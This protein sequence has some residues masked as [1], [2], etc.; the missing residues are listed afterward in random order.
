MINCN[1][2]CTMVSDLLGISGQ[3]ISKPDG[4]SAKLDGDSVTIFD[5]AVGSS[6]CQ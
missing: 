4:D 6:K 3:L 5:I 1:R 2:S